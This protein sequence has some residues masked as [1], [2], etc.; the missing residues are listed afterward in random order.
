[1][2]M[3]KR[4]AGEAF[5]VIIPCLDDFERLP[6]LLEDIRKQNRHPR[7]VIVCEAGDIRR[8]RAVIKAHSD[9]HSRYEALIVKGGSPPK[10]R[11]RGAEKATSPL[12]FFLDADV[13][14]PI[15]FFDKAVAEFRRKGLSVTTA[16]QKPAI[17]RFRYRILYWAL[18]AFTYASAWFFPV[19]TGTCIA[20]TKEAWRQ[21][22]G[23]DTRITLC[24]DA[25]FVKEVARRVGRFRMLTSTFILVDTRRFDEKGYWHTVWQVVGTTLYRFF[26]GE[27]YRNR[28]KYEFGG[29]KPLKS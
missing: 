7:E 24:E 5:S 4:A 12:L 2:P 16:T 28:F 8:M 27:D 18:N 25:A 14:L 6:H 17:P 13:R 20:A 3:A 29:Y 9:R 23:F 21:V 26:K 10:A 1:M 22:G 19:G 15:D 11:N